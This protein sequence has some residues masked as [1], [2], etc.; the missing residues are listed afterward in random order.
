MAL[1]FAG[2]ALAPDLAVAMAAL[3]ALGVG[4]AIVSPSLSTVLSRESHAEQQGST[5]GIGQSSNAAARAVGPIVAGGLF[6]LNRALPYAAS[7]VLVLVAAWLLSQAGA[8]ACVAGGPDDRR[9][10]DPSKS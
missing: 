10:D 5:L 4:Q 8:P 6:D 1:A 7:A 9:Q 3:T 2:L